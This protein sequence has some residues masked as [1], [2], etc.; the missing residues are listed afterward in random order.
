M[1]LLYFTKYEDLGASSR[2]RSFQFFPL[3]KENGIL[4]DY[5]ALFNNEY[6]RN[7]Y[8]KKSNRAI[9]IKSYLK[10]FLY[11]FNIKKY[12]L[13]VIEKELFPYFPAWFEFILKTMNVRYIVDYDDPIFHNYDL[14]K[15]NLVRKFLG[16]KIDKVMKLSSHVF[17]GNSYLEDRAKN[18]GAKSVSFL[19]TVI[20]LHRYAISSLK[21][22]NEFI[23]GWIGSPSTIRYLNDL[24]P[25]FD[26]LFE[27]YPEFKLHIIGAK[28]NFEEINYIRYIPWTFENEVQEIYK[29]DVGIMPLYDTP[30]EKGKCSYKLIQYMGCSKAVVASP[31]GS[32]IQVVTNHVNGIFAYAPK[33]WFEAIEFLINNPITCR[34]YGKN[35]LKKVREV[36]NLE[37]NLKLLIA[38]FNELVK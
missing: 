20:D 19:P 25:I 37:S 28:P 34:E 30:F 5:Q 8:A 3:L 18:A 32:N 11:L 2:L 12:D 1:K 31:I 33:D 13:I 15:N 35:G 4:I 14:H 22:E 27:R 17:C 23:V 21:L 38:R 7:L 9:I 6:V 36:Y 10:R 16:R 26:Q 24:I 29:F